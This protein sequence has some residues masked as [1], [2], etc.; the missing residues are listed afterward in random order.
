LPIFKKFF[1]CREKALDN[2]A[3]FPPRRLGTTCRNR[4][5]PAPPDPLFGYRQLL[6]SPA[7]PIDFPLLL[8]GPSCPA[9]EGFLSDYL[10]VAGT[11]K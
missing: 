9:P 11:R 3:N 4:S 10:T 6:T 5:I 7:W 2:R 1:T 8:D